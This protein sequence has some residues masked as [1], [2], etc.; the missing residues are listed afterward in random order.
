M[1]GM[2]SLPPCPKANSAPSTTRLSGGPRHHHQGQPTPAHPVDDRQP[3]DHHRQ[4]GHAQRHADPQRG[5]GREAVVGQDRRRVVDDHLDPAELGEDRDAAADDQSRS[6][7]GLLQPA[8][9]AVAG[10]GLLLARPSSAMSSSSASTSQPS[11]R[12]RCSDV[13]A[14][15]R[16]SVL[17]QPP[18]ALRQPEHQRPIIGAGTAAAPIDTRQ[19]T[20]SRR[21][22]GWRSRCR[23]RSRAGSEHQPAADLRRRRARRRT[24][25]RS[26]SP[27]RRRTRAP[28]GRGRAVSGSA[29]ARTPA[30]PGRRRWRSAGWVR[31]RP[32]R[33][34]S[35]LHARAPMTAPSRMLAAITCSCR[36]RCRTPRRSAAERRR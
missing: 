24:S 13:S 29:R 30:C 20:A 31:C 25:A 15:S 3:D 1:N 36:C 2:S 12:T 18:R 28:S 26:G 21:R 32:H 16:S 4:V 17:D 9:A 8:P 14:L 33:S 10:L 34:E 19:S 23:R 22:P 27:H 7:P 6:H 35:R 11:G 5:G